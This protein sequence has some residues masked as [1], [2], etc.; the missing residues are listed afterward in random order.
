MRARVGEDERRREQQRAGTAV[1]APE[2]RCGQ[3]REGKGRR[4]R[5][6][7]G[8]RQGTSRGKAEKGADR[9]DSGRSPNARSNSRRRR[10]PHRSVPRC[11]RRR[12]G[13][14]AASRRRGMRR[15]RTWSAGAVA[16]SPRSRGQIPSTDWRW[17]QGGEGW[18]ARVE[19]RGRE[20]CTA[21]NPMAGCKEGKGRQDRAAE[22]RRGATA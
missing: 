22:Q 2:D 5:Q 10:R 15:W 17:G 20:G 7:P 19:R 13:G 1:Y 4:G 8:M 14:R 6:G 12:R 16:A 11:V 18:S 9:G 21:D 3:A